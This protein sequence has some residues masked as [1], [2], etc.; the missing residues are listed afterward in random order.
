MAGAWL[1]ARRVVAD[2]PAFRTTPVLEPL[3]LPPARHS[4]RLAVPADALPLP[5]LVVDVGRLTNVH[6]LLAAEAGGG[7]GQEP[8][9]PPEL[10]VSLA[11]A[12]GEAAGPDT[13]GG[14]AEPGD[15][16]AGTVA[17]GGDA[18]LWVRT[19]AVPAVPA[20]EPP[21]DEEPAAIGVRAGGAGPTGGGAKPAG[22]VAGGG[23]GEPSPPA[24]H[25]R[26]GGQGE[27][28]THAAAAGAAAAGGQGEGDGGPGPVERETPGAV[29]WGERL[30][31]ELLPGA[32]RGEVA[33]EVRARRRLGYGMW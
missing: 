5:L 2:L 30:L 23:G 11:I 32:E 12:G 3:P 33:I 18:R 28:G 31:L 15:A 26:S 8:L 25:E 21:Q 24:S 16:D 29:A 13:P 27:P 17:P 14:N 19:R 10:C 7:A 4:Q 9:C 6:A 20:L 1:R 22:G